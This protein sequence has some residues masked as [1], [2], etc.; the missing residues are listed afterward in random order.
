MSS[1]EAW[2]AALVDWVRLGESFLAGRKSADPL[3][4]EALEALLARRDA[5][6]E[7]LGEPMPAGLAL[8]DLPERARLLDAELV[9]L[10]RQELERRREE[11]TELGRLRAALKGYRGPDREEESRSRLSRFI[12]TRS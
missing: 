3:D 8:G 5:L 6:L 12:D 4:A 9:R 1:P 10:T 11:L 7:V 2:K